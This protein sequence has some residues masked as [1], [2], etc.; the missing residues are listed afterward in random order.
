MDKITLRRQ[1]K[2]LNKQYLSRE[3][4]STASQR[5]CQAIE[6]DEHFQQ[7][8]HIA[9]Y[10]ALPDEPDLQE[11]LNKYATLKSLYLPRVEGDDIAFYHYKGEEELSEGKYGINEPTE[12]KAHCIDPMRLE[13]IIVPGMAFTKEGI[14]LGRGK[15]YYDRFLP[16]TKAYLIGTTFRFRIFDYIA[17][18][19]WDIP[20]NTI[21]ID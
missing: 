21:I 19:H 12:E 4:R 17:H 16:L 15:A 13:L 8:D 10:H 6:A 14:R 9:L 5:I 3:A 11:L 20:M 18:D 7:A 1:V 2:E